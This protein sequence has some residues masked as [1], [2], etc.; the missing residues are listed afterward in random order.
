MA[1]I[2]SGASHCLKIPSRR[3]GATRMVGLPD[4]KILRICLLV[5]TQYRNMMDRHTDERTP[6]YYPEIICITESWLYCNIPNIA[7]NLDGYH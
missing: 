3:Y 1:R 4:G 7:V 2:Q 6:Q 5:L